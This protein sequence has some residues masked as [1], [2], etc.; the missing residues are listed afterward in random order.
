MSVSSLIDS[1]EVDIF[2]THKTGNNLYTSLIEKTNISD[3]GT[4]MMITV[5]MWQCECECDYSEKT[6]G[7]CANYQY[8]C[9]SASQSCFNIYSAMMVRIPSALAI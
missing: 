9:C 6:T 2:K 5:Q 8:I 3:V 1:T 7:L 4:F